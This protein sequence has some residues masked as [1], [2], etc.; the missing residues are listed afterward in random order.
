MHL[1][2]INNSYLG[3]TDSGRSPSGVPIKTQRQWVFMRSGR[4]RFYQQKKG[5]SIGANNI[6]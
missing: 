6:T 2:E 5:I 4:E 1:F 3:C